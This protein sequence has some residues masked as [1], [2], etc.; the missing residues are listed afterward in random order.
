[1]PMN[2]QTT[3]KKVH[4][5]IKR[6][7][8]KAKLKGKP[9]FLPFTLSSEQYQARHCLSNCEAEEKRSN[10][11]IVYGWIIWEFPDMN[12]IE[13]EFHAVI[14]RDKKYIDVTPRTDGEENIMFIPDTERMPL[15]ESPSCWKTWSNI[16][17]KNGFITD[18]AS[19]LYLQDEKSNIIEY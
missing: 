11:S 15:R 9:M 1:M 12:F 18:K 17:S 8:K 5:G 3:P 7:L 13:A 2:R 10:C 19:V 6:F 4:S 16:K 14:Y